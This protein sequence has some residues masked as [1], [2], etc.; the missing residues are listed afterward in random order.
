MCCIA[1]FFFFFFQGSTFI[2]T[3]GHCAKSLSTGLYTNPASMTV[4]PGIDRTITGGS[5]GVTSLWVHPTYDR[6]T[7]SSGRIDLAVLQLSS[8]LT[9]SPSVQP[10]TMC[11]SSTC[12]K[13]GL[14]VYVSGYGETVSDVSSSTQTKLQWAPLSMV[15]TAT[16]AAV[17]TAN[18]LGTLPNTNICAGP[19]PSTAN[20]DS[21][22]GD[23]GGPLFYDSANNVNSPSFLLVG[24]VSTGTV[25]A[26]SPLPSCGAQGN[27]GVYVSVQQNRAWITGIMSGTSNASAITA[28]C[29]SAGT[30]VGTTGGTTGGSSVSNIPWWYI[31]AG[32][33]GGLVLL[34]LLIVTIVRCCISCHRQPS[35]HHHQHRPSAH[36][37]TVPMAVV[38]PPPP[39]PATT[40]VSVQVAPAAPPAASAPPVYQPQVYQGQQPYPPVYAQQGVYMA[41]PQMYGQA[42]PPAPAYYGGAPPPQAPPVYTNPGTTPPPYN[43]NS[44]GH[45]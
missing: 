32:A 20:Y 25:P 30:C 1:D 31:V 27:Y 22:F 40:S 13:A 5:R 36:V 44:Y 37:Q 16:C 34:I 12:E 41:Q 23:S 33:I 6:A 4:I 17:W 7:S 2:L 43:P 26:G 8:P 15:S 45:M 24:V 18:G 28:Q 3:A 21:C 38:T 10:I 14:N 11:A 42:P 19:N 39:V 35:T 9:L 29:V